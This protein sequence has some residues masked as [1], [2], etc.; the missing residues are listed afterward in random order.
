[1]RT[2]KLQREIKELL[3]E[4]HWT[5]A[6]AARCVHCEMSDSDDEAEIQRYVECFKKKLSRPTTPPEHLEEILKILCLQRPAQHLRKVKPTY[7]PGP[8]LNPDLE[9]EMRAI[10]RALDREL[11]DEPTS[12]R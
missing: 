3:A 5:L 8:F 9:R 4:M 7:V 6:A 2:N 12:S 10:S 11:K 1:M